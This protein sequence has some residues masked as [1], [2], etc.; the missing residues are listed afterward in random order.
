[1]PDRYQN[2]K[3]HLSAGFSFA[4]CEDVHDRFLP[5]AAARHARATERYWTTAIEGTADIMLSSAVLWRRG[6]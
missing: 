5:T 2:T 6:R 1:M 4:K 3:L